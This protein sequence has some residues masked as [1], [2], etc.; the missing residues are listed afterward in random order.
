MPALRQPLSLP[1]PP[2]LLLPLT[3]GEKFKARYTVL[4]P[5]VWAYYR[6][7]DT[8]ASARLLCFYKMKPTTEEQR[9]E[10]NSAVSLAQGAFDVVVLDETGWHGRGSSSAAISRQQQQQPAA[11]AAAVQRLQLDIED[12]T[13]GFIDAGEMRRNY[14]FEA[15]ANGDSL[16]DWALHM[17]PDATFD[18]AAHVPANKLQLKLQVMEAAE[19]SMAGKGWRS[20]QRSGFQTGKLSNLCGA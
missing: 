6:S 3:Q 18:V 10:P 17:D 8:G 15:A 13:H 4:L 2:P 16:Q 5:D 11:T 7:R 19:E 20:R 14:V 12:D 9:S 1:P